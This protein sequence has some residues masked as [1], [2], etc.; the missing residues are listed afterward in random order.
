[1]DIREKPTPLKLA[2]IGAGIKQ[3]RL[4]NLIGVSSSEFSLWE[5]GK[6]RP[7]PEMK[8]RIARLLEKDVQEVFPEEE[9]GRG[10]FIR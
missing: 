7:D 9:P 5:T 10:R 3:W 1:M 6:R 4:A 8:Y 2:R